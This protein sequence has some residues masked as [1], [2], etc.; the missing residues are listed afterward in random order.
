MTT[1]VRRVALVTAAAAAL[2]LLATSPAAA[3]TVS[4]TTGTASIDRADPRAVT[5]EGQL[6]CPE[7]E[8]RF[9]DVRVVQPRAAGSDTTE[10]I[11]CT[12]TA[13]TWLAEVESTTGPWRPGNATITA[14]VKEPPLTTARLVRVRW[15][16]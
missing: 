15:L 6:T 4:I 9:V 8:A 13:Q 2:P 1:T 5:I 3:D 11:T 7:G 16:R 10:R 12:G 14:E